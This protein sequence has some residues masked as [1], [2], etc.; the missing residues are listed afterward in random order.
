MFWDQDGLSVAE[1]AP[2]TARAVLSRLR[3]GRGGFDDES[4]LP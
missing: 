2:V 1:T 4:H 3:E